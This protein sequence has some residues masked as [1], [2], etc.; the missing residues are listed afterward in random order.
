[1]LK[2]LAPLCLVAVLCAL[3]LAPL[4]RSL[5][6]AQATSSTT[7]SLVEPPA[8]GSR[9]L[10]EADRE[11]L[12]AAEATSSPDLEEMRAGSLLVAVLLIILIIVLVT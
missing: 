7:A 11:A 4:A 12:M 8:N 9:L 6:G 1:M 5:S 3:P 2:R 10:T